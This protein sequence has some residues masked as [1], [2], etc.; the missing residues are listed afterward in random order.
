MVV[1]KGQ[2]PFQHPSS[3]LQLISLNLA[4]K[5]KQM[6]INI[7]V[8]GSG[9]IGANLQIKLVLGILALRQNRERMLT[10]LQIPF[11]T[12]KFFWKSGFAI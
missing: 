1:T 3:F 12:I 7:Y 2:A 10:Q 6:L 8:A 4:V 9:Y 11:P 5:E